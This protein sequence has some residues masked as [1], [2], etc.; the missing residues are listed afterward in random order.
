MGT[1]PLVFGA[2]GMAKPATAVAITRTTKVIVA[3][4]LRDETGTG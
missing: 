3:R 4:I 1:V 2:D